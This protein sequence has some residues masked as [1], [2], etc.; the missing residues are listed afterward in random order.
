MIAEAAHAGRWQATRMRHLEHCAALT[1]ELDALT[2]AVAKA[3][4]VAQV[5]SCPEWTVADLA[6]HIGGVHR[7]ATHH[8]RTGSLAR[9]PPSELDLQEP[10]DDGELA[11]W[12][13]EGGME[14]V[15]TLRNADADAPVWM[16]GA[17][18]H[19]RGWS[20]RMLHETLIHRVDAE[21]AV[22]A[23]P[24]LHPAE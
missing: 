6:H 12:L 5:P 2:P 4:P 19:V 13:A 3:D 22:G 9:V 21:R 24:S 17:D 20:R 14:L 18:R 8:V 10:T 15:G 1:S 16:W 11:A 7:W 23:D